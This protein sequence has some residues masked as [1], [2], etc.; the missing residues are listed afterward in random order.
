MHD[1][2]TKGCLMTPA[3]P[4]SGYVL[5][6]PCPMLPAPSLRVVILIVVTAVIVLAGH[7][8]DLA[9]ALSFL[10]IANMPMG[11]TAGGPRDEM[12]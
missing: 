3:L 2:L 5:I 11:T 4:S 6:F 8:R 12:R 9:A 7:G 1:Y 10:T